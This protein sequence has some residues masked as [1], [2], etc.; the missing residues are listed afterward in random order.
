MKGTCDAF[1]K[2]EVQEY[3]NWSSTIAHLLWALP[4]LSSLLLPPRG[5]V[6][7]SLPVLLSYFS[8]LFLGSVW[9]VVVP[10][11]EIQAVHG[12]LHHL[13]NLDCNSIAGTFHCSAQIEFNQPP[14]YLAVLPTL[15][16]FIFSLLLGV[17]FFFTL[18]QQ[19]MKAFC[20]SSSLFSFP[21]L[22]FLCL[23]STISSFFFFFPS[24]FLFPSPVTKNEAWAWILHYPNNY[25]TLYYI[26][27]PP[28]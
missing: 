1:R 28:L 24:S 15:L 23:F 12:L 17:L 9:A 18:F 5:E 10:Q 22:L 8:L 6:P 16:P 3:N 4:F 13:K 14:A 26:F 25:L 21:P 20:I 7:P 19:K 27:R 2:Q 11:S